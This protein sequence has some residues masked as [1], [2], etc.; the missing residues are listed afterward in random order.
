[1]LKVADCPGRRASRWIGS[2]LV[3]GVAEISTSM[4]PSSDKT[5]SPEREPAALSVRSQRDHWT[6]A[7]QQVHADL[8]DAPPGIT[9]YIIPKPKYLVIHP[10][11]DTVRDNSRIVLRQM[12]VLQAW[13]TPGSPQHISFH[14]ELASSFLRLWCHD[15]IPFYTSGRPSF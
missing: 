11:N 12:Q 1:M 5:G 4:H 8:P 7:V 13:F 14:R 3:K 2:V 15:G 6:L 10:N 9:K